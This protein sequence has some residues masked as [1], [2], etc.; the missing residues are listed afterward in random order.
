MP[1]RFKANTFVAVAAK[2]KSGGGWKLFP[3]ERKLH[4]LARSLV[5]RQQLFLGRHADPRPTVNAAVTVGPTFAT[6]LRAATRLKQLQVPVEA[7]E[8]PS[9]S[10]QKYTTITTMRGQR[11]TVERLDQPSAYF[12][13]RVSL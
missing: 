3:S 9:T 8:N 7:P 2:C 1:D 13:S 11:A 12:N 4:S 10:L 5:P 6:T